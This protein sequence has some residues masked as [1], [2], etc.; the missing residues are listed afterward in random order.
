MSLSSW[1]RGFKAETRGPT[2]GL[3][4]QAFQVSMA[5]ALHDV[6]V[7][8][9]SPRLRGVFISTGISTGTGIGADGGLRRLTSTLTRRLARDSCCLIRLYARRSSSLRI[10]LNRL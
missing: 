10:A 3:P 5:F 9:L 2:G 4:A 6:A 1:K 7:T 8:V